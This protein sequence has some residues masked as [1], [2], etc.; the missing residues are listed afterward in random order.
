MAGMKTS[1][2]AAA[3][4]LCVGPALGLYA[5]G[6]AGYAI[7]RIRRCAPSPGGD[8]CDDAYEKGVL[9]GYGLGARVRLQA[10]WLGAEMRRQA[11]DGLRMNVYGINAGYAF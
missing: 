4:G 9:G 8:I 5:I 11:G 2:F 7:F 3:L 6:G 1:S 10:V